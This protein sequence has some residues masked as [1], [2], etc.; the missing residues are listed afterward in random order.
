MPHNMQASGVQVQGR[1]FQ[2][3]VKS[4]HLFRRFVA[5]LDVAPVKVCLKP[6]Q[7]SLQG[8]HFLP[9]ALILHSSSDIVLHGKLC[10]ESFLNFIPRD[11][12]IQL[13]TK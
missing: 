10:R 8:L 1:R 4:P 13:R 3:S 9:H 5:D 2:L 12:A 11:F 6:V 7:D